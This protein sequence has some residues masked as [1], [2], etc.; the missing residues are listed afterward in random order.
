MHSLAFPGAR[1]DS[2]PCRARALFS[3][4]QTP[5]QNVLRLL[6]QLL[7]QALAMGSSKPEA[8]GALIREAGQS[9]FGCGGMERTHCLDARGVADV[10]WG[11]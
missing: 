9:A 1:A 5:Q 2:L 6:M 4:R 3:L 11:M 8:V 7:K 10:S